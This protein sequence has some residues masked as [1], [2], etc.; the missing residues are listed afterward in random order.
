MSSSK[1]RIFTVLLSIA[2]G[3]TVVLSL[4][5]YTPLDPVQLINIVI[6]VFLIFVAWMYMKRVPS[7]NELSVKETPEEE[8]GPLLFS[9]FAY[10]VCNDR[11]VQGTLSV[12]AEFVCFTASE[13]PFDPITLKI[14]RS[15][16]KEILRSAPSNLVLTDIDDHT[17]EFSVGPIDILTAVLKGNAGE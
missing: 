1:S 6:L 5:W 3:I 8:T 7:R 11:Y 9:E 2:L 4:W 16:L 14:S 10:M 12:T 15:D 13:Q 17:W